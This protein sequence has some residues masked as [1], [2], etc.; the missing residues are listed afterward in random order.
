MAAAFGRQWGS[1]G[2]A[3]RVGQRDIVRAFAPAEDMMQQLQETCRQVLAGPWGR[4]LPE[5]PE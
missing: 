3:V 5:M 1:E 4:H 2:V